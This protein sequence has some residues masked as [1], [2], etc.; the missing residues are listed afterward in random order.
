MHILRKLFAFS[1]QPKGSEAILATPSPQAC[2]DFERLLAGLAGRTPTEF[3][4][5]LED[6]IATLPASASTGPELIDHID[7]LHL[8][9][10]VSVGRGDRGEDQRYRQLGQLASWLYE[11]LGCPQ[12]TQHAVVRRASEALRA[13]E[14]KRGEA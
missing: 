8:G 6:A 7:Q 13:S 10:G 4:Q 3:R 14:H 12:D 2:R 1:S 5:A 9:L 11:E